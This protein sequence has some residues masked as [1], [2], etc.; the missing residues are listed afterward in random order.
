MDFNIKISN[1]EDTKTKVNMNV[2]L[3]TKEKSS[4][5]NPD[6]LKKEDDT[7]ASQ[8]Q[9]SSAYDLSKA[10]HPIICFLVATIKIIGILWYF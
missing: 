1:E 9:R 7:T 3:N 8:S 2:P 5:E 4:S 10:S 6:K